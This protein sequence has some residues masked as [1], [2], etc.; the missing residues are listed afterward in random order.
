M[1]DSVSADSLHLLRL[2]ASERTRLLRRVPRGVEIYEVNGPFF[3]G[4][5]DKLK[6]VLGEIEKKP[7]A[8]IL[9]MRNV[10]AIDATGIHALEQL[11]L[12][13]KHQGTTL[14]L[15]EVRE[16]PR[17]ALE[18]AKKFELFENRAKTLDE[19]LDRA[20]LIAAPDAGHA[21]AT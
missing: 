13:L 20:A 7:K 10:P 5:A 12:K 9:R 19:A 15:A 11:A 21:A 1:P 17:S 18:R 2:T 4:A 6:D 8:F 3:F 14:I 16:Q